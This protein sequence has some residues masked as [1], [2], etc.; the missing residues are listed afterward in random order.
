MLERLYSKECMNNKTATYTILGVDKKNRRIGAASASCVIGIGGRIQ[1]YRPQIGIVITQHIDTPDIANTI[2]DELGLGNDLLSAIELAVN[3][4][5]DKYLRQIAVINFLGEI[6]S[7]SGDGCTEITSTFSEGNFHFIG[8]TLSEDFCSIFK[9]KVEILDEDKSLS[10]NLLYL[11]NTFYDLGADKRGCES[12]ALLVVP[13]EIYGWES[14][15]VNLRVDY[16]KK[17]VE[18]LKKLYKLWCSRFGIQ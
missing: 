5:S 3:S 17:P 11:L 7:F 1:F 13:F 8:N 6:E 2:F 18:D 14:Q 9:E 15:V 10:E 16:S 12:A 4:F